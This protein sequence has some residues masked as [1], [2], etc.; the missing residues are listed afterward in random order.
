VK[1]MTAKHEEDTALET[2]GAVYTP[3]STRLGE[4]LDEAVMKFVRPV[5]YA[6]SNKRQEDEIYYLKAE[7]AAAQSQIVEQR[8]LMSNKDN[9]I[10][11]LKI[12]CDLGDLPCA[13]FNAGS[14]ASASQSVS[15][16]MAAAEAPAPPPACVGCFWTLGGSKC[17]SCTGL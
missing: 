16:P 2:T 4:L 5:D 7:L 13:G 14:C 11:A 9:E 10:K 6:I 1:L 3:R 17:A 12:I 15:D 8:A